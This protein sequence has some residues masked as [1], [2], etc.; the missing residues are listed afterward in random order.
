MLTNKQD[1]KVH[2]QEFYKDEL[3]EVWWDTKIK[4][5]QKINTIDQML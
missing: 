3:M 2:I 4:T 5:L 1:K